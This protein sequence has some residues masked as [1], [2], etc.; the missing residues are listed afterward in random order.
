[1]RMDGVFRR[2]LSQREHERWGELMTSL[3][4]VALDQNSRDEV[5]WALDS[6]KSFTTKSL[7]RFVT[8]RGVSIPEA[9]NV[10]KAKLPLKIKIFLWQLKHNKLQV[11]TSLKRRGWKGSVYCCLCGKVETN[12]HVFFGCLISRFA[13]CCLRDAFGWARCPTDLSDLMGVSVAGGPRLTNHLTTFIFAGFAWAIWRSRNNMAIERC[14][15][16][17][18]LEVIHSGFAFM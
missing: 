16:G 3:E 14:F 10:W 1:M 7:Y 2:S 6:S 18:P 17:N 4:N 8:N 15:P 11:A 12:N 9:E 5:Y 13:W